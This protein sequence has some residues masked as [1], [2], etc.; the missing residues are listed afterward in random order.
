MCSKQTTTNSKVPQHCAERD[1][2]RHSAGVC[3]RLTHPGR[4]SITQTIIITATRQ[5]RWLALVEPVSALF[6]QT[7]EAIIQ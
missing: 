6:A 5:V 4:F 2:G 7:R 1:R 3:A